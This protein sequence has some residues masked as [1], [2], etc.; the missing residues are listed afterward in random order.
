[1]NAKA[2]GSRIERKSRDMLEHCGYLVIKSA[3]SLTPFDLVAIGADDVLLIQC[4]ANRWPSAEEINRIKGVVAP[5]NVRRI[6]HRWRDR[7]PEPDV[8]E[9]A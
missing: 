1:M 5:A 7:R 6:V 9:V 2:K 8:R 3:A 4:K